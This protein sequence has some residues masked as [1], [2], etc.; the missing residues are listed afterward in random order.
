MYCPSCPQT[1]IMLYKLSIYHNA[2]TKTNAEFCTTS[3]IP[4]CTHLIKKLNHQSF[5]VWFYMYYF[6]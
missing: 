4:D 2:S 5:Q 3:H 6:W 1:N